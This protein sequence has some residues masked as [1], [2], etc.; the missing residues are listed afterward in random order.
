MGTQDP[1]ETVEKNVS[2]A[3]FDTDILIDAARGIREAIECLADHERTGQL[4]ISAV[5]KMELIGFHS[6]RRI[7][8][9]IVSFPAWIC[10]LIHL[11]HI[12]PYLSADA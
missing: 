2:A 12:S 8:R 4:A 5:T 7:R 11:E 10:V 3:L 1:P 6:S 9:I